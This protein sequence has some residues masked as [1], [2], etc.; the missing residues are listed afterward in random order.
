MTTTVLE[1]T[2]TQQKHKKQLSE[3]QEAELRIFLR[4]LAFGIA[5]NIIN[6]NNNKIE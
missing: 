4:K 5:S 6:C 1:L 2:S 3:Q